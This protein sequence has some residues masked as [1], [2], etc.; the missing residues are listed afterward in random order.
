VLAMTTPATV[1][2]VYR[3]EDE[4]DAWVRGAERR[5]HVPTGA[6][7]TATAIPTYWS[8]PPTAL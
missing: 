2:V 7:H 5:R 6:V 3:G 4:V 1:L 8:A